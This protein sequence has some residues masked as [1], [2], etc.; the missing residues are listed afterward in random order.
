ML[1]G[2]YIVSQYLKIKNN[3]SYLSLP[4]TFILGGKAAPGYFM[5]KL[6][7][8]F[9]NSIAEV[10]NKD[11]TI[12]DRLKVVFLEDYRVSL[13]ERIF[14]ASDLS[15]Q[16][17][18]A[19]TEASGTGCMKFMLNGA[20]TV[21]TYDGA[22]VEMCEEVGQD[23][24]FIFG[25]RVDDV[26]KIREAGYRPQEYIDRSPALKEALDFIRANSFCPG[27]PDLFKPLIDSLVYSDPYMICADFEDY[28]KTQERAE[29]VYRD[30]NLWTKKSIINVAKSGKFSSDRTIR[31]YAKDIWGVGAVE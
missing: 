27:S 29:K 13:A 3:P 16:I 19:G 26:K 6:I 14:P 15:E 21:G 20:L 24:I 12:G 4:R 8:R 1:F 31:A 11:K 22:N 7:I 30:K 10:I 9:I 23:N 18:L 17:S 28:R 5:A 25:L 2:M